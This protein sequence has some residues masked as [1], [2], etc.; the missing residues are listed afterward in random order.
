[1][2][3]D[4]SGH[5][6]QG[7]AI[8]VHR[9]FGGDVVSFHDIFHA[10]HCFEPDDVVKHVLE[11]G[12]VLYLLPDLLFDLELGQLAVLLVLFRYFKV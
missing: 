2:I 11:L 7:V 8:V 6:N 12:F 5:G 9:I 10:L 1:M 4:Y 3:A